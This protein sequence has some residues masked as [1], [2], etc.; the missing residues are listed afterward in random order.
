MAENV[1]PRHWKWF[2]IPLIIIVISLLGTL[3]WAYFSKYDRFNSDNL[4]AFV[5]EFGPW[6]PLAYVLIY[7][8]SS[9]IPGIATLLSPL[10]GLLFGAVWGSVLVVSVATL[11]ALIPFTMSRQLGQEWVATKL[12]GERLR[13]IYDRSQGQG[14]FVFVMMMRLVPIIPWEVQNYIAGLTQIPIPVFL[15][16]TAIGIIPGSVSLVLLGDSVTDPSS[17]RF[18]A[19]IALNAFF[20]LGTPVIAT[21]MNRRKKRRRTG[22]EETTS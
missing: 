8:V 13:D 1:K 2:H 18:A 3:I 12:K 15:L 9:P 14:G 7:I 20:I 6:A 16:A 4:Q 22:D 11:S 19:A 10:G 5:G 17:G 21:L